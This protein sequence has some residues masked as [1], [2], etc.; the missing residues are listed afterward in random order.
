MYCKCINSDIFPCIY[1]PGRIYKW[2][3]YDDAQT[4]VCVI[5]D[6]LLMPSKIMSREEFFHCFE[7]VD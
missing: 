5:R 2:Y 3:W 7:I 4:L 6:D 1:C